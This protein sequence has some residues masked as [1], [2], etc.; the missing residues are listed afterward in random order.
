MRLTST[1]TRALRILFG[2]LLTEANPRTHQPWIRSIMR[3]SKAFLSLFLVFS[4]QSCSQAFQTTPW[5]QHRGQDETRRR[6]NDDVH[7]FANEATHQQQQN[8]PDPLHYGWFDT[9]M[10]SL[11]ESVNLDQAFTREPIAEFVPTQHI[12]RAMA[13]VLHEAPPQSMVRVY[14]ATLSPWLLHL[15]LAHGVTKTMRIITC[16]RSVDAVQNF[17]HQY[18]PANSYDAFYTRLQVRVAGTPP[19]SVSHTRILTEPHSLHNGQVTVPEPQEL[20]TFDA[21]WNNLQGRD[22][23]QVFP[24]VYPEWFT[25]PRRR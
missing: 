12:V 18:A 2:T 9:R 24:Q 23:D 5:N 3:L 13:R 20:E 14:C 11:H 25:V 22:L 17:L 10:A 21:L 15:L 16:Q 7:N 8:H 6:Y 4:S 19:Q 1:G